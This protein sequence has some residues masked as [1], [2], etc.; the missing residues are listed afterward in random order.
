MAEVYR[1]VNG[2]PLE[3]VIASHKDAQDAMDTFTY[4]AALRAEVILR[5]AESEFHSE[6]KVEQADDMYSPMLSRLLVLDDTRGLKA[7]M[8]IEF[9][10]KDKNGRGG[11]R[12]VAP[13]RQAV[14]IE[15]G[16]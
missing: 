15:V 4:A 6:I 16:E 2:I 10:R 9:G 11:M 13:L 1:R 3:A 7:A 8:S 14:G 12:A 5:G